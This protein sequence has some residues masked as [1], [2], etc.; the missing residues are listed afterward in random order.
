[1][2]NA[3]PDDPREPALRC[4][5][6]RAL[7]LDHVY[8]ALDDA[9]SATVVAHVATCPAC[10]AAL[11]AA[12][13]QQAT[14]AEAARAE[15]GD[16]SFAPP[17][18]TAVPASRPRLI[19]RGWWLT[20]AAAA[21]LGTLVAGGDALTARSRAVASHPVFEVSGPSTV[22]RG[23][24]AE[25]TVV[26]RTVDGDPLP[27]RVEAFTADGPR[28]AIGAADV[29]GDR[30][31]TVLTIDP[32]LLAPGASTTAYFSVTPTDG[33]DRSSGRLPI[34]EA[35]RLV[36]RVSTDKPL[37]RP[38]ET[39][40][41][42]GVALES[43]RL[44]PAG[45]TDLRVRL[46]DPR[47]TVVSDNAL[48]T[49]T[50]VTAWEHELPADA[51]GGTWKVV[52]SGTAGGNE[53][54]VAS[55][56][57]TFRVRNYRPPRIRLDW[58]FDRASYAPGDE[59][60]AFLQIARS[61]GGVPV[62]ATVEAVVLID[63]DNAYSTKEFF[64]RDDGALS[65]PFDVK[66][67]S[68]Q[69]SF[70]MAVT[71]R[72]G[73]AVETTVKTIPVV[74]GVVKLE[75]FP[76]GG[77]LVAGLPNRVY[78]RAKTQANEAADID[79]ELR[80]ARG[81]KVAAVRP[82]V[83]GMGAFEFTPT[84]GETYTIVD[85][86]SGTRTAENAT[87][88]AVAAGTTLRTLDDEVAAQGTVR[89]RVGSTSGGRYTVGAWCRGVQIG[90]TTVDVARGSSSDASIRLR[91][92][93]GGVLRVTAFD[94]SNTPVAERLVSRRPARHL[95]VAVTPALAKT[96]PRQHQ[97]VTVRVTD[98]SGVAAQA[99]LGASVV[100]ASVL[101]LADDRDT[102]PM[103][104]HFLV[105]MEVDELEEAA[106]YTDGPR[107]A[108]AVDRLLGVQGWRRFAWRDAAGF[109][110][111]HPDA[112]PR[113]APV[114]ASDLPGRFS[115]ES[116]AQANVDDALRESL[117]RSGGVA[118][119]FLLCVLVAGGLAVGIRAVWQRRI[120]AAAGAFSVPTLIC[121]G[122][123]VLVSQIR[124]GGVDKGMFEAVA[125][126]MPGA[127]VAAGA[128]APD[129]STPGAPR[130]D[131]ANAHTLLDS[132][133]MQVEEEALAD[134]RTRIADLQERL[135]T[136]GGY[137]GPATPSDELED[138]SRELFEEKQKRQV[139]RHLVREYAHRAAPSAGV[140]DDFAEV[141]A[142]SPLLVTDAK[143]E[144]TFSF[145]TSDAITSF[146]V[147]IDGHDGRGALGSGASE[148]SNRVPFFAEPKF[149]LAVTA[150]DEIDLPIVVANDSD[151]AIDATV[152]LTLDGK[153]L[154]SRGAATPDVR[155]GA[156][157][158]NRTIV[159]IVAL[160]AR[161]A[162]SLHL[163][164]TAGPGL[165][166]TSRRTVDVHPRGY[167]IAVNRSGV[168]EKADSAT[169][170]L[171]GSFS[172]ETMRGGVRIYPSTLATLVDG[173]DAMLQEPHG[174]FEQ[175]SSSN[176]PNVLVLN[177]LQEQRAASPE[178]ARRAKSLLATGYK[179][180]AG[181]ECR[182]RGYEW[183]GKDPGHEGLTAYGVL[184]FTDMAKVFAV[185]A[186]MVARTRD[187]LLARRNGSGGFRRDANAYD[188]FARA[189]Q[190]VHDA[191]I[192]WALSE[193]DTT[194]DLTAE[195]AHLEAGVL[196][197]KDPYIVALA[198]NVFGNRKH[199]ATKSALDR[200]VSMQRADGGF[201]AK[202]TS[203]TSS[204]G[205]NL[206]IETTALAA[207]AFAKSPDRLA[208]GEAAV[209][210]LLA[211]RR[212]GAFG[213]TQ[214]T[215]LALRAL[216]AH[217]KASQR[218]ATDHDITVLVNGAAVAQRHIAAGAPGVVEIGADVVAAL[219]SGDN[220]VE[221]RTTG[222]EALPWALALDYTT[223]L[224]AND[225]QCAVTIET[226]LSSDAADEGASLEAVVT[227]RNRTAEPQAMTLARIGFPAGLEPRA[228]RLDELKKAG[229]ID[230]FELRPR[231][232]VLYWTGL[233]ASE[234]KRIAF[235][236][237]ASI[238]GRYEGPASSAYLYYG[239]DR[240]TWAAPLRVTVR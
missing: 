111:S 10:S 68:E 145:D 136:P 211:N 115:N 164:V 139:A 104:F 49:M 117:Q 60:R 192:A 183:F 220:R 233:R 146:R 23:V 209:R 12:R 229:A 48:P 217:A 221:L 79:A 160:Q 140:R 204:T 118:V 29:S 42:R 30:P 206:E 161:G 126:A 95:N 31:D 144:A 214:A 71:V 197:G 148:F 6:V 5:A 240:K 65:V 92:E 238:P 216:T 69:G 143:G 182:N 22:A 219:V 100:D 7:L 106:A 85:A 174:C 4:D 1:M 180:L 184:E 170:T 45:D 39:L 133:D 236:L 76:E 14:L 112:G 173:L 26:S 124:C 185:D 3:Q 203:I 53:G 110:A 34:R 8:G 101:S 138:L 141:L 158:R 84:A 196:D 102:A 228:E 105:G 114:G 80:D 189:P 87:L 24:P 28:R 150:G 190:D 38:G 130:V 97:D 59:G 57:R 33:G 94:A 119:M 135:K 207:L 56:E 202:G 151:A 215:I 134:G 226:A 17:D 113:V 165:R 167:P 224:P 179:M 121:A 149:P 43:L 67:A 52:L 176:Y 25:F 232:V 188:G 89:V 51:P 73:G 230:F 172:R 166:D 72:D 54:M 20:T 13:S 128:W 63:G 157:A 35:T 200:L 153:L 83:Q 55:S 81:A 152:K 186:A 123:A 46:L 47:G 96:A 239:D 36:S 154:A 177:Y 163:D 40:R 93:V 103:A 199:A 235:D 194:T 198:A 19:P 210:F 175:T 16:V 127:P 91:S 125:T 122:I 159:P 27:G 227:V 74:T 223:D 32:G 222:A 107:A 15:A 21:L 205:V 44:T 193:A 109:A 90:E 169:F 116:E 156:G 9:E 77:A 50:G 218:M 70:R 11:D 187:W 147:A 142:W 181:Y 86:K 82:D 231:E 191:Y 162:S 66:G 61:E 137:L 225:P 201:D 132:D 64:L 99:I 195:I 237:T 213:A 75:T 108:L 212:G 78:F 41:V 208:S 18:A 131:L 120:G 155:V 168:L 178:I 58:E 2:T 129:E 88:S 62:G 234:T 171:P 37:Y 98:E